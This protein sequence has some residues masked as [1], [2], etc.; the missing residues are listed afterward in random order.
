MMFVMVVD[1]TG[2]HRLRRKVGS[3]SRSHCLSGDC[4]EEP[5][6]FLLLCRFEFKEFGGWRSWRR[7]VRR[8]KRCVTGQDGVAKLGDFVIEERAEERRRAGDGDGSGEDCLRWRTAFTVFQ[9]WREFPRAEAMRL[10]VVPL[11]CKFDGVVVFLY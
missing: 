4:K 2:E 3:G 7:I 10:D 9:S 6:R 8:E 11:F 5:F 1:K